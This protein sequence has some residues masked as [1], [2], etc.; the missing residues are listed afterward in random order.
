[1]KFPAA[2]VL[3]LKGLL[4]GMA[5]IIPG[6]SGGTMAL[7]TGIYERLIHAIRNIDLKFAYHFVKGDMK[8]AKEN[9]LSID[10]KFLIPLGLGIATA[11]IVLAQIMGY[12]LEEHTAATYAFF[13]GL[14]IAS[15]GIVSKYVEKIDHKHIISGFIGF[16]FVFLIIG[17]DELG[18][19]HSPIMIFFSGA[20]AIC[21]MILPGI[22]GSLILLIMGQYH[23]ML[24]VL[25]ERKFKEIII[26]LAGAVVG[27]MAFSR[28][29]DY[30]IKN[31]KSMTMAF[32]FGLMLGALRLPAE[33]IGSSTDMAL[34]LDFGFIILSAVV[35]FIMV[36]VIE[37][38]SRDIQEKL[39]IEV[40]D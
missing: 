35:G 38:K 14:I 31:H 3:F 22:S 36:A 12:L 5:D 37:L 11:V 4:M 23:Y 30:M 39:G 26:F 28:L 8:S 25:N 6:V 19:N 10:F 7:I 21:A 24:D 20:I 18:E 34:T 40:E 32:L 33:K 1:M 9:F 17:V 15:T 16:L 27:L 29:L 13:F 2:L